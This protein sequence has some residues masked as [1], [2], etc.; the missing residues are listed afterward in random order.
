MLAVPVRVDIAPD[1]LEW[2]AER[3][4]VA[5][6]IAEKFPLDRWIAGDRQPTLKQLQAFAHA[7]HTSWPRRN[8]DACLFV[9]HDGHRRRARARFVPGI[10]CP[11][12]QP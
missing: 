1:V 3:S 6:E 4:G 11:V 5:D 10:S 2:A 7:T 12:A 8:I 9:S